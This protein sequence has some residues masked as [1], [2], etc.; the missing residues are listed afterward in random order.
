M[1]RQYG[2]ERIILLV[3]ETKLGKY[4]SVMVVGLAYR[5][6]CIPLAFWG[7]R[8]DA[9]PM[10]QVHLIEELLCWVAEGLPDGCIPLWEAS[11][12]DLKSDGWQWQ[13]SRIFTPHHANLLVLVLAVAYAFVLSLG[14]LAFDEPALTAQLVDKTGSVFRNGLCLWQT[15]LGQL[16]PLLMALTQDFFVFLDPPSLKTVGPCTATR[17]GGG[18]RV[19]RAG[20]EVD[21]REPYNLEW[22]AQV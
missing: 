8:P 14:T 19:A 15:F 2:G 17:S 20:G 10:G 9:W 21:W 16:H 12:R 13:S 6:C 4:W 18:S 1:R 5:G 3:D 11:L 22:A 7:Y